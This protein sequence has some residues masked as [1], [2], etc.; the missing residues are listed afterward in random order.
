MVVYWAAATLVAREVVELKVGAAAVEATVAG[1]A[2]ARAVAEMSV[3]GRKAVDRL[4][5]SLAASTVAVVSTAVVVK[6]PQPA[7]EATAAAA[8]QAEAATA[9]VARAAEAMA[10][11][12]EV[13]AASEVATPEV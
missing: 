6:S 3:V 12:H 2:T 13:E 7:P 5:A 8:T 11:G 4:V 10:E 9:V 1:M